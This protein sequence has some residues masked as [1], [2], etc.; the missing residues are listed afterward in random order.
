MSFIIFIQKDV[1]VMYK[2]PEDLEDA[3]MNN[4]EDVRIKNVRT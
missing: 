2:V 3:K 4:S 1:F